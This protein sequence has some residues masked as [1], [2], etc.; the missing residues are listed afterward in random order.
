[1]D[2]ENKDMASDAW[3]SVEW[4]DG[5]PTAE[6]DDFMA[7]DGLPINFK[8]AARFVVEALSDAANNC[9]ASCDIDRT[10]KALH[11]RFSTGG[12]S[13][14]E[15]LI[16]FIEGRPDTEYFMM[17]WRRGGHYEFEIPAHL[18][19]VATPCAQPSAPSQEQS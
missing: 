3:P 5:Y 8:L 18:I 10:E 7:W 1:M 12:W 13:G 11:V 9:C 19:A 14:A 6:D 15:S 4:E 16:N 17:S 2:K